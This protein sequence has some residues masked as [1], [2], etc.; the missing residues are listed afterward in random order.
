MTQIETGTGG[1]PIRFLAAGGTG[2]Q[3]DI[4]MK[5]IAKL[6]LAAALVVASSA[7]ALAEDAATKAGA[8][9]KGAAG[10][11]V[12][13]TTTGSIGASFD[14]LMTTLNSTST[15]DLA[16]V[17]D[18][19]TINFVTVSSLQGA[20]PAALDTALQ[21]KADA[22]TS[23]HASIEGNAALKAKIEAGG[24]AVDDIIAVETGADGSFTFYVDDRA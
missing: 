3:E 12:D 18:A 7:F 14:T 8:A 21:A 9:V 2:N 5:T 15:V 19:T 13:A 1:S 10:T 20:D 17:T 6:G 22:M 24:Y 16:A 11:S 23:L 4:T